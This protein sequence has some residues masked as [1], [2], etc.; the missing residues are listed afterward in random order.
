MRNILVIAP[1]WGRRRWPSHCTAGWPNAGPSRHRPVRP[2]LTLAAGR[3][4][5]L[6]APGRGQSVWP[7]RRRW[8]TERWREG[9]ALAASGYDQAIVLP[10][11]QKSALIPWFAGIPQRTGFFWRVSSRRAQRRPPADKTALPTMVERFARWA[12][13]AGAPL[14][15]PDCPSPAECVGAGARGGFAG[16][17]FVRR[18]AGDGIVPRRRIRPG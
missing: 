3:A 10:N 17:W 4:Y 8:L 15:R 1:S 13:D 18:T 9:R 2:G 12:E 5:G 6:R 16:L 11:S 14:K 7:W